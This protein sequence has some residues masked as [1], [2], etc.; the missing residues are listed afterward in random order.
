MNQWCHVYDNIAGVKR[1]VLNLIINCEY[2]KMKF[3]Y[4]GEQVCA[5]KS[6]SRLATLSSLMDYIQLFYY[7]TILLF[8][9][10]IIVSSFSSKHRLAITDLSIL[11]ICFFIDRKYYKLIFYHLIYLFIFIFIDMFIMHLFIVRD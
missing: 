5:K 11:D 10:I 1:Q 9:I 7:C 3:K 6:N 4:L 2:A 8:F